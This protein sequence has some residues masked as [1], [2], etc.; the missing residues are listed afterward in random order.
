MSI[1]I[2]ASNDLMPASYI[3]PLST[4][5][6]VKASC[7]LYRRYFLTILFANVVPVLPGRI[8]ELVGLASESDELSVVSSLLVLIGTFFSYVATI[9]CVADICVGQVPS[10]GRSFLRTRNVAWSLIVVFV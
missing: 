8:V 9:L 2:D 7:Q 6:I 5:E 3:P 10:L 4:G 1:S